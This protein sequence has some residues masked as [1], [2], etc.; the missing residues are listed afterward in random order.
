MDTGRLDNLMNLV[1]E[2]VLGRNRLLQ[3]VRS[4]EGRRDLE[5]A[6]AS[7]SETA[8]FID[9]ITGD[10]QKAVIKTRMQPVGK[11]FN[12]FPRIVRDLARERGKKVVLEIAG[13]DT[14]LDKSVIDEIHDP[15]VHLIRN[16]VDHGLE[17]PEDRARAGKPPEGRIRLA[18]RQEGNRIA[19]E[20]SD[21]GRGLDVERIRRKGLSSGL[22]R[23]EEAA[24]IPEAEVL[25]LIFRPGFST[26]ETVDRLS[27][28]GVG[29]DVVKTNVERLGGF[30]EMDSA[31]GRGVRFVIKL[32][33]TLAII[34]VL[35]VRVGGEVYAIPSVAVIETIRLHPGE[36]KT[37]DGKEVVNLRN[38]ILPLLRI[39]EL[40]GLPAEDG[41][42]RRRQYAVVVGIAERRAGLLIH[43]VI[44]Q[45]EVVIK[46]LGTL[47]EDAA[48]IAGATIRGDGRVALILD[49]AGLVKLSSPARAPAPAPRPSA[50]A[51]A[52]RPAPA[53]PARAG[54]LTVLVVDDSATE[55]KIARKAVEAAGHAVV[56]ASDGASALAKL[57]DADVDLVITDIEMEG[58][59][60]YE[61]TRRIRG[62]PRWKGLPVVALSSHGQMVDRIRGSE[63]GVDAY[64]VK[65]L[66]AEALAR[67][68]RKCCP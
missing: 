49:I 15:L 14:E 51:L 39:S 54:P 50:A 66:D 63:S 32:P 20:V 67:V 22:I 58:M 3:V 19:L 4:A 56:E 68:I 44:G 8:D 43:E 6:L 5:S 12:K 7:L 42:D 18:A 28:R 41:D 27:G 40:F 47:F 33:L 59:D 52:G 37:V 16:A 26:A 57:G 23:P 64:L 48:G 17:K 10:L 24:S 21:D 11:I 35:M 45:E 2:M 55:R 61:F 65:P 9:L 60:G 29:M 31:P 1:G 25:N 30:V 53:R 38:R 36:R 34:P 62:L 46:P 13:A